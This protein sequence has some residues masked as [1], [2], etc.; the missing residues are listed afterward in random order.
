[1]ATVKWDGDAHHDPDMYPSES[2]IALNLVKFVAEEPPKKKAKT[3]EAPNAT[4]IP[5]GTVI[6]EFL[7]RGGF[8]LLSK[9]HQTGSPRSQFLSPC[10]SIE[11]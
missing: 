1:M 4:P 9:P 5:E 3:E 11:Y 7:I 8:C 10:A 6:S 2:E